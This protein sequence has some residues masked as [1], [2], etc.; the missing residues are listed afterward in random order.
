MI[1][2]S[3]LLAIWTAG[4]SYMTTKHERARRAE[5]T[6]SSSGVVVDHKIAEYA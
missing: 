2:V 5:F 3:I 4:L 6:E 1:A